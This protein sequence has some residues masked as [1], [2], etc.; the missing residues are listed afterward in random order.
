[1]TH[2]VEVEEDDGDLFVGRFVCE[3]V[4]DA[5]CRS[6][7][8]E[9]EEECRARDVYVSDEPDGTA[10]RHAPAG[11]HRFVPMDPPTCRVVDYLNASAG[12]RFDSEELHAEDEPLRPGRHPIVEEWDGDCYLWTYAEPDPEPEYPGHP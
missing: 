6:W 8:V 7:C 10:A 3:A 2:L 1:M 9:C 5:L 12:D 4:P 11:A